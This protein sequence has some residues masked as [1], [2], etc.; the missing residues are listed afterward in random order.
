MYA[1]GRSGLDRMG[2]GSMTISPDA[3]I[4][5]IAKHFP[6]GFDF[7][8]D[9]DMAANWPDTIAEEL[10]ILEE[11]FSHQA[12]IIEIVRGLKEAGRLRQLLPDMG[13]AE[14]L[15]LSWEE[16]ARRAREAMG[17]LIGMPIKDA[18]MIERLAAVL[19]GKVKPREA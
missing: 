3:V 13:C 8:E 7:D 6:D 2:E 16:Q 19:A 18:E 15:V 5:A 12:P 10:D 17:I 9:D 14:W 4:D 11:D 1:R